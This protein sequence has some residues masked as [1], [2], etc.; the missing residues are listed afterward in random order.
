[1][2]R[3]TT[4]RTRWSIEP[5]DPSSAERPGLW[6]LVK[7]VLGC[8]A[9]G[10]L[11]GASIGASL[12]T[13]GYALTA[14]LIGGIPLGALGMLSLSWFGWLFGRMNRL[15]HGSLVGGSLGL[16]GAGTLGAVAGL[17]VW[18]FPWSLAGAIL[19]A[20]LQSFLTRPEL[21]SLGLFPGLA[22]G[23]LV[24]ILL[25]AVRTDSAGV[26]AGASYGALVGTVLGVFLIP[27]LL[28]WL[29]ELPSLLQR[30]RRR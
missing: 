13:N 10:G 7:A 1:M 5:V 28:A 18:A 29:T 21:R 15:R 9:A 19:G 17:S 6:G 8:G 30:R 14:A 11:I 24:G 2:N 25:R 26:T 4:S 27:A 20:M 22:I 12:R 23:S 3:R 16:L